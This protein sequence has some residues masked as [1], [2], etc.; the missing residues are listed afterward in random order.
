MNSSLKVARK[1]KEP[2][3]FAL[4]EIL[5]ATALMA[6]MGT[7]MVT[8]ISSSIDAKEE[9]EKVSDRYHVVRQA[10]SRMTQE[11]S[12]AYLSAHRNSFELK[13]NTQFK[14]ESDQINFVAFGRPVFR[15]NAKNSDQQEIG[16][17]LDYDDRSGGQAIFRRSQAN[18]DL[19]SEEGGR[20]QTLCPGVS[21]LTF[22]Y[23]DSVS[24]DWKEAWDTEE[25]GTIGRLPERIKIKFTADMGDGIEQTFLTQTKLR[26]IQ[27]IQFK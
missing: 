4:M 19:E 17:T 23:W 5:I 12:M 10:M 11:L 16:Y 13:V 18:P 20:I 21:E 3:G 15:A 14:G 26:M 2:L 8:T 6:I 7:L 9:V 27:P 25:T 22:E 1:S 24:T